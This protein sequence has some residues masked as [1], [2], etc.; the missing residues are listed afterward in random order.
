MDLKEL[1]TL[2]RSLIS[3]TGEPAALTDFGAPRAT[4]EDAL[5]AFDEDYQISRFLQFTRDPDTPAEA[6]FNINGVECTHLR[7]LPEVDSLLRPQS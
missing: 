7:I 3:R 1:V 5:C 4:F 2:Y 6:A